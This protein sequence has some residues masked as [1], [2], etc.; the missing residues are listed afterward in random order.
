MLGFPYGG[1]NLTNT[2]ANTTH[3]PGGASIAARLQR[4]AVFENGE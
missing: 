3:D 4:R 2:S 1:G